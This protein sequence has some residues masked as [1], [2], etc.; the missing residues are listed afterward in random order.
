MQGREKAQ[1]ALFG[2]LPL[3]ELLPLDHPLRKIRSDFDAAYARLADA[4]ETNYGTTGN[5]SIPTPILIRAWLLMAL[6][7]IQSERALCE[8]ITM[9]AAFVGS[10][11]WMGRQGLR[12]LDALQEP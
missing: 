2:T 3:E 9:N 6:Y 7:S 1:K 8:Q 4:F 5:V 11:A 12:P 10:W